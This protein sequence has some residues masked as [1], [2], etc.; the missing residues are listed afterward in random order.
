[1]SKW[2]ADEG[3][4]GGGVSRFPRSC[5]YYLHDMSLLSASA[6]DART[7]TFIFNGSNASNSLNNICGPGKVLP[8]EDFTLTGK[9][10]SLCFC[11]LPVKSALYLWPPARSD[12]RRGTLYRA[13]LRL[14]GFLGDQLYSHTDCNL[15]NSL[16][17]GRR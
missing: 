16:G 13:R 11:A 3:T 2:T 5:I 10:S 17:Q 12:S 8:V 6:F 1:M 7:T 15:M 9:K 14:P 4:R